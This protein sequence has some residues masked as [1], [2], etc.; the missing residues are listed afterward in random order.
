MSFRRIFSIVFLLVLLTAAAMVILTGC[1]SKPATPEFNNP[2]DPDGADNGDPFHLR[3]TSTDTAITLFW[4]QV[5]GHQMASYQ[6]MHS[7]D[8]TGEFFTV[9]T[10]EAS[11]QETEMFQYLNPQP[12]AVHYFK[13][14]AFDGNGNFTLLSHIVPTTVTT[15]AQV[16]VNDG[17]RRIPSRLITLNISISAGDSLRISQKGLSNSEIVMAADESGTPVTLPWDLGTVGT[18]DTTL[19]LNV[20]VQT[21]TS[22]GDT[23]KVEL[24][25]NFDPGFSLYGGGETVALRNPILQLETTGLVSM[26]FAADSADLA[27]LPW[28]P[29]AETHNGY[30]LEDSANTQTIYGEFLGDFGF[31][32][33]KELAVTPDLLTTAEFRLDLPADHISDQSIIRGISSARASLMRFSENLDFGATPW[34]AYEDSAAITLSDKPGHKNIYA[35]FRND[36]ADSP[37]LTD[38]VIYLSQPLEVAISAPSEGGVVRGGSVLRV[39]GISIASSGSVP[40][41]LV[42]FDGGNGFMDAE[43]TNNWSYTWNIPR[44]DTDTELV[45]RA[46]AF[47]GD[48]SITTHINVTVTQLAVAITSPLDGDEIAGDT[49]V[50][51]TGTASP[52]FGGA[53]IDSVTITTDGSTQAASG[54]DNWTYSWHPAAVT[55]TTE[56]T[57][58]ATVHAGLIHFSQSV[59]VSVV[60]Q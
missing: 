21:G 6:V 26:R 30:Q 29:G 36:F 41:E 27:G 3:A 56:K 42:K 38:Y 24:D 1:D 9:G 15:L 13:I 14:Q 8:L 35:Q 52:I 58:T 57:I 28:L 18:N 50:T 60:P 59:N 48:D 22:L 11:D 19:V 10:L 54:T 51:V 31:S 7:L 32:I 12:T 53:A 23:N 16:I 2:F 40:V 45:I 20:V 37:I 43:G 33:I 44:F 55:E 4:D 47:A 25:I 5:P 49:D 46:R 39:Q 17:S 34:Q